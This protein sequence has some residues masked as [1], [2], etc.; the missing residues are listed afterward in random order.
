MTISVQ[1]RQTGSTTMVAVEFADTGKGIPSS[2]MGKIFEPFFTTKEDGTGLGLAT[3]KKIIEKHGG[4]IEVESETGLGAV[5]R[6]LLPVH[7]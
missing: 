2:E 4:Q 6:V 5:F 3:T 7:A 1:S